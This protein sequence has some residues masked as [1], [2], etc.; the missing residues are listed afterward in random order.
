MV[1]DA[2]KA[3][4]TGK[5]DHV[6]VWV[7]KKDEA[8]IRHAFQETLSV[9]KLS[10]QAK[11]FADRYFFETLVRIHREGEGAPYTGIKPAGTDLGPAVKGADKALEPGSV[12]PLV[13]LVNE[14]NSRGDQ[15]P[16]R[17]RHETQ[18]ACATQC[19]GRP[20]VCRSIRAVCPLRG[21]HLY[22]KAAAET[23]HHEGGDENPAPKHQHG[24]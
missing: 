6:L 16:L 13:K 11:A 2:R 7:Q 3:L 20:G 19:R 8:E 5:V 10:P 24:E 23:A 9:R 12:E 15:A 4:D 1:S 17:T 18:E 14:K 22:D 21:R